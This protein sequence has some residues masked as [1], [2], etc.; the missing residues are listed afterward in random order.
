MNRAGL[1]HIDLDRTLSSLSGGELS[2]L[3]LASA[4]LRNPDFILLDEPTNHLD[5]DS[6]TRLRDMV[7]ATRAGVLIASHDRDLLREMDAILELSPRGLHRYGGNF[8]AYRVQKEQEQEAA[9][10]A[11]E[12]A[13]VRLK[14][15]ERK[16]RQARE[17]QEKRA[18]SGA[19]HGRKQNMPKDVINKLKG[20]AEAT[21]HKGKALHAKRVEASRDQVDELRGRVDK[22]RRIAIDLEGAT[23]HRD[24][25]ILHL[26]DLNYAWP[27]QDPLWNEPLNRQLRGNA[28]I[29]LR[30][31]NG[32]GKSTLIQIIRGQ[33]QPSSG[34][35]RVGTQQVLLL[36]QKLE[37]LDPDQS[38]LDNL[39]RF[40]PDAMPEHELRTRLARF[41]FRDDK[42]FQKAGD[43]S[44]GERMRL[45]LACLLVMD[46]L[47][48][49]LI[50][51]EPSNNLDLRSTGEL[52]TVLATFSG[53]LLLVTHDPDLAHEI[54]V[55][56]EWML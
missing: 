54:G 25:L 26:Q 30:G 18:A 27:G 46:Q 7:R 16:A 24:K 21:L 53:A 6:R 3:A 36:D 37:L 15:Q 4:W 43:L 28:K 55:D 17:R 11:L 14:Q 5:A 29:W 45:A 41:L 49:L 39:R 12:A 1:S 10:G 8:D 44:G 34:Q 52:A 40:A 2:R 48:E 47:P 51:D 19:K 33:L 9:R 31:A 20:E 23:A 13:R 38:L 42:V 22:N 56:E 50:L 32:S 35:V